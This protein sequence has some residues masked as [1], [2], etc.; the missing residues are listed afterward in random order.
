M[1]HVRV[2][3]VLLLLA[4]AASAGDEALVPLLHD[5]DRGV[6]YA[7]AMALGKA[8]ARLEQ[9]APL[10]GDPEWCVRQA[11][12][13]AFVHAGDERAVP[14]LARALHEGSPAARL[15][16]AEA[17]ARLGDRAVPW[18]RA[19][20]RDPDPGVRVAALDGLL[21]RTEAT[22]RSVA[23]DVRPLLRSRHTEVAL[24]AA[25]V[26]HGIVPGTEEVCLH[27]MREGESKRQARWARALLDGK[28][29]EDAPSLKPLPPLSVPP[30]DETPLPKVVERWLAFEPDPNSE[31]VLVR[32]ASARD[33]ESCAD[34][35]PDVRTA[36]ARFVDDADLLARLLGDPDWRVRRNAIR[37]LGRVRKGA[38]AVAPFL[39]DRN[40]ALAWAAADALERMGAPAALPVAHALASGNP[41]VFRFAPGI[42]RV[43][44]EDGAPAADAL[45]RLLAHDDVN[46]RDVAAQCLGFVADRKTAP[47]LVRALA[48]DRLPV[49]A[50]AARA[51]GRIGETPALLEALRSKRARVRAYA[52]FALGEALGRRRGVPPLPYEPRLPVLDV[53][54]PEPGPVGIAHGKLWS[55]D[56]KVAIRYAA[57]LDYDEMDAIECERA[58]ELLLPEGLRPG[59]PT[60]FDKLRSYLG[61]SELGAFLEYFCRARVTEPDRTYVYGQLHRLPRSDDVPMLLH[62]LDSEDSIRLEG[63]SEIEQPFHYT[64]RLPRDRS[65]IWETIARYGKPWRPERWWLLALDE[66]PERHAARLVRIARRSVG[67]DHA[68]VA[69]KALGAAK[70]EAS[71]RFLRHAAT[72]DLDETRIFAVASLARRGDR[73]A[74]GRLV[75]ES[76][77]DGQAV[78]LL[79]ESFPDLARLVLR[80]RLADPKRA[81]ACAE[82]VQSALEHGYHYG[83]RAD[84]GAFL[85]IEPTLRLDR[86][87]GETLAA[88]ALHVPGCGTPR[89]ARALL[90]RIRA[91]PPEAWLTRYHGLGDLHEL[92]RA[93]AR[94]GYVEVLRGWSRNADPEVRAF[95]FP[96]LIALGD[97]ARKD[98]IVEWLRAVPDAIDEAL[99]HGA[100]YPGLTP[101]LLKR[102]RAGDDY[103]CWDLLR[104]QGAP[105]LLLDEFDVAEEASL[106]KLAAAGHGLD[107]VRAMLG[108]HRNIAWD[109]HDHARP[110]WL[111][112]E[113]R[114]RLEARA[115]PVHTMFPALVAWPDEKAQAEYWSIMRAG[116]YR[117]VADVQDDA[118]ATLGWNLSALVHW[119]FELESNCCRAN[120]RPDSLFE[121]LIGDATLSSCAHSGIG[122]PGTER[123]RE[124]FDLYGVPW[125][126]R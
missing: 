45:A 7:A 79:L 54:V 123:V 120:P 103:G 92:L 106:R 111:L 89:V 72:S 12:E 16:A 97:V 74:L 110:A 33:A 114:R 42:F 65:G 87:D 90:A 116:R 122:Q 41:A 115:V 121:R 125:R 61:S 21:R 60:D 10:L 113:L 78:G 5:R 24:M 6:R 22:R 36:A 85:G 70:D 76:A 69:I 124:R 14:H 53:G 119:A 49:V 126:F 98:A 117:W 104:Y 101:L 93:T 26:L 108:A 19:A 55:R 40:I 3:A 23:D 57:A 51:L 34:P 44:G 28:K 25:H 80:E 75:R 81:K 107:W 27:V 29:R 52:A 94:D 67:T 20:L 64:A 50:N 102:A 100:G 58:V 46:V 38:A 31:D 118:A 77:A 95:A 2:A 32:V 96:R 73:S 17:L 112:E 35:C 8:G 4:T 109:G 83:T 11:A 56:P 105:R 82:F 99:E 88:I 39:A 1:S 37:S 47:A 63:A 86:L 62:F 13:T 59:N 43:L 91:R 48:D 68:W 71:L 9:V 84:P 66:I 30:R 18:L 15:E